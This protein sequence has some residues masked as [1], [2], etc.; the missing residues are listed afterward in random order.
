MNTGF[1]FALTPDERQFFESVVR[2]RKAAALVVRRANALLLLD[3]G[4][5]PVEIAKLLYLDE[6]TIR[7]WQRRFAAE[8]R[9]LLEM[10]GYKPREGH[11]SRQQEAALRT[12]L[13][14]THCAAPMRCGTIS[15]RHTG[16]NSA[17]Q[18]RSS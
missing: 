8:G 6:E 3:D 7:V 9:A 2:R 11:L 16:R 12:Y 13:A 4:L 14:P 5:G 18:A 10:K 15:A 17:A 1:K